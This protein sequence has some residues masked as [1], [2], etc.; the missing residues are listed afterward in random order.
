MKLEVAGSMEFLKSS[1]K[2]AD[3][4]RREREHR[5]QLMGR[6]LGPSTVSA[7]AA[8]GDDAV[9]VIMI[10]ERA[11]P[12]MQDQGH[13]ELGVQLAATELEQRR[14][15]RGA[16]QPVARRL[17]L[18]DERVEAG[19]QRKGEMEIRPGPEGRARGGGGP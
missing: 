13:A 2:L 12:R 11:A 14:R 8:A 17:V 10:V 5:K 6:G 4:N 7:Q 16:E 18:L 9:D 15:S 3:K 1:A 19:R